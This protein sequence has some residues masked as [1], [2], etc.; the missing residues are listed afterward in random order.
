MVTPREAH[1]VA[2]L[3]PWYAATQNNVAIHRYLDP[4]FVAQF[5]TDVSNSPQNNANLFTWESEDRM[6]ADQGNLLKLRRPVHRTFHIVAWEASCI[7]PTAPRGQPAIAPEKIA[8][9]G[10]VLRDV[11]GATPLGFQILR[12]KPQG[13]GAFDPTADPDAV[14][15]IKALALVPRNAT[16]SPG[17]TGE[18]IFPLHPLAVTAGTTPHTL[19]YG[20]LPIGGGDYVP[21]IAAAPD[22][23]QV[24]EVLY[25]PFGTAGGPAPAT[26]T[27]DSQIA[28]GEIQGPF[29]ALLSA[30]LGRY[31]LVDPAA[32][33]DPANARL[34]GIL[35][36]LRFFTD[37]PPNYALPDLRAWAAANP[38]PGV[39]LG[40][41]LL[42]W[43]AAA[44]AQGQTLKALTADVPVAVALLTALMQQPAPPD[45]T[46]PPPP[47]TPPAS[48]A[49][50]PGGGNLLV[51]ESVAA[52]LRDA[53]RMRAAQATATA[54]SAVPVAKL[55]S[56]P[57]G[58]Y[59]VVPF[60]RTICPNGCEKVFWG[61]PSDPFAV[62]AMFD[63]EAS[64]P[65]LIEMPD[66]ADAKKGLV[67]GA[68]FNLPPSLADLVTGLNGKDSATGMLQGNAP[69][70]GLGIGFICSFSL[71]AIS[72]CAM[73]M[74]SIT[75]SLLNIF[76]GWMAW[77]K[78]CLPIPVKK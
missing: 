20:Y 5:Q 27:A 54:S 59:V 23:S 75:L 30:L 13:W 7:L 12:G 74:L 63:P 55:V 48:V 9:A 16:P 29:A 58:R 71:P 72:I 53:L 42:S 38:V 44:P 77:V 28:G 2:V 62:A 1:D 15:Q 6:G 78:I 19:L 36:G 31:Q 25:W 61:T 47:V 65:T 37:P 18:E 33:S 24:Q 10:F 41:L 22:T 43:T 45:P 70:G 60:V 49:F 57:N 51:S 39:T 56:G 21:P 67:R 69:G 73:L 34:I 26:Y 68:S 76:L 14:R 35:G 4:G 40:S 46:T 8:S 50:P 32:W 66:L 3:A 11:S 64:R 52:Q 17:Y